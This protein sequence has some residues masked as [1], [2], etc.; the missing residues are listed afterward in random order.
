MRKCALGRGG[1]HG[2]RGTPGALLY[3]G[4][5]SYRHGAW[6]RGG[7]TCLR[8]TKQPPTP[9]ADLPLDVPPRMRLELLVTTFHRAAPLGSRFER[10]PQVIGGAGGSLAR[11]YTADHRLRCATPRRL[12][13]ESEHPTDTT[14]CCD[15][16]DLAG[17]CLCSIGSLVSYF[18]APLG[19]AHTHDNH[20][21]T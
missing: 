11:F 5:M 16:K 9:L 3:N 21:L 20:L 13:G 18:W 7:R 17:L 1:A 2:P 6:V 10:G 8:H 14:S 12:N 15:W 19:A 4:G